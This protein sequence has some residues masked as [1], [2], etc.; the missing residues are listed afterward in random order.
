MGRLRRLL[1]STPWSILRG[2]PDGMEG[3]FRR[4][5]IV[6]VDSLDPQGPPHLVRSRY[7][8]GSRHAKWAGPVYRRPGTRQRDLM[9]I[10][11]ELA[12]LV[13]ANAPLSQG[14]AVAAKEQ[15]RH[16][17]ASRA[18]RWFSKKWE[19]AAKPQ[20]RIVRIANFLI[21]LLMAFLF[22]VLLGLALPLID[23]SFDLG[24]TLAGSFLLLL[25]LMIPI[26]LSV[27]HFLRLEAVF[28]VMC[29]RLAQGMEVSEMLGSLP[30]LFPPYYI[31]LVKAGE[32]AGQLGT[33]LEEMGE[34]LLARLHRRRELGATL[35]YLGLV[36]VVQILLTTF[37]GVKVY[38][39]FREILEEFGQ[40]EPAVATYVFS[41]LHTLLDLL[42]YKPVE[43]SVVFIWLPIC[44]LILFRI[45]GFRAASVPGI[46]LFFVP[47]FRRLLSASNLAPITQVLAMLLEA[48]MPLDAAL[49]QAAELPLNPLHRRMLLRA[50]AGIRR[51]DSLSA[52]CAREGWILPGSF[53][54]MVAVGERSGMLPNAMRQLSAMYTDQAQNGV[55]VAMA[56]VLPLGVLALGALTLAIQLSVYTTMAALTDGVLYDM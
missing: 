48:G 21:L 32:A 11:N 22:P 9:L 1:N 27:R 37:I 16:L 46:L 15:R 10:T 41:S 19:R 29:D 51:G 33:V 30:R 31:G 56:T 26:L 7:R 54:A 24:P 42:M 50:A 23:Q 43:L 2:Q 38:P 53:G 18:G 36:L 13:H 12:A 34:T 44:I 55:R 17:K 45:A 14:L 47:P 28:L 5:R 35:G 52:C 6:D 3:P 39:V 25:G 8:L 4:V 20:R 40:S 49:T